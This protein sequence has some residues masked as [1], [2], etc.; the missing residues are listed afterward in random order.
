MSTIA[1]KQAGAQ[2]SMD[3]NIIVGRLR[4]FLF[5]LSGFMCAGTI[6]ELILA[7]HTEE[8]LQFVPFV[9]CGLGLLAVAA[10]LLRPRRATLIALRV[11]MG[12]LMVGSLFGVYEHVAGNL[13]FELE[14][15]PS[16]TASAVWLQALKGAAP[17]LAP[18]VLALAAIVAL[19]ATYYHPALRRPGDAR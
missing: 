5:A 14:I 11:V 15:R 1:Q 4:T 7:E 6:V 9:L 12:A 17:L 13:A 10:A 18:G 2:E 16:A 19:A 8:P 3:P